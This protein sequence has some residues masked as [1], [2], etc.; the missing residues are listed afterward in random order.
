MEK[1]IEEVADHI[2]VAVHGDVCTW[3]NADWVAHF[4][5]CAEIVKRLQLGGLSE[6]TIRNT[7]LV[8]G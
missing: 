4:N 3:N 7:L 5:A 2:G 8:R 1:L 6:D